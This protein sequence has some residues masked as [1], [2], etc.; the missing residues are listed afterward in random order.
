MPA[1]EAI[2]SFGILLQMGD[3]ADPEVFTTI[4][5]VRDISPPELTRD[6]EETTHHTS[7]GG[8]E[9]LLGTLK[10]S[11]EV[12]FEVNWLPTDATHNA[13][14]GI[15]SLYDSGEITNFQIIFPDSGTTTWAFAA[16]VTKF[17][18]TGA[19]AGVLRGNVTFKPTG[20]VS[21]T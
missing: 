4:A 12:T 15:L 6:T 14:D 9:E 16:I 7:P 21:L 10:R 11:G 1:S 13:S 5:E 20:P 8:W 19:V 17:Q 2:S 3:G 18:P